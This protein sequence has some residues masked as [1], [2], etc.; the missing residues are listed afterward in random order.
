[1]GGKVGEEVKEAAGIVSTATVMEEGEGEEGDRVGG[2]DNIV[3]VE[4]TNNT[5]THN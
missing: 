2:A 5:T 4:E 1:M 3:I